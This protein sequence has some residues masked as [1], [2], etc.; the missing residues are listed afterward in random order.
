MRTIGLILLLGLTHSLFGQKFLQI[1]KYGSAKVKKYYI[2]DDLNFQ[3][4]GDKTW[5]TGTIQDLIIDD[6]IIIL[7]DRYVRL[8]DIRTLRKYRDWSQSL[9]NKLFV[10]AGSW[11]FFSAAGA[12]FAGWELKWDT[13]IIAGSALAT[14]WIIKKFFK[15]KKYKIGK[16]RRLRMLDITIGRPAFGP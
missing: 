12:L 16:K 4:V 13:A 6:D 10:F 14:G 11:L 7:A 8:E 5:Y 1:E 9:G 2:G 15:Y 3:L